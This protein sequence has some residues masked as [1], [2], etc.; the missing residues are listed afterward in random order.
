LIVGNGATEF[1][2]QSIKMITIALIHHKTIC[3]LEINLIQSAD[4]SDYRKI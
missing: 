3:N 4:Q 2:L 1:E